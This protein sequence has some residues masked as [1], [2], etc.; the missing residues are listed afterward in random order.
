MKKIICLCLSFLMVFS[1]FTTFSVVNAAE[2]IY[3]DVNSD[4]VVDMRDLLFFRKYLAKMTGYNN[5]TINSVNAD[6][7]CNGKIN[8][9][10]DVKY[11]I[12]HLSKEK[13]ITNAKTYTMDAFEN[14]ITLCGRAVS[15]DGAIKLS[16]SASGFKFK[17]N[18]EGDIQILLTTA[19]NG[20]LVV[21]VDEDYDNAVTVDVSANTGKYYV[22]LGLEK[23]EHTIMIQKATEWSVNSLFTIN[24]L[25]FSGEFGA[26]PPEAKT[27][28][29][30]FYGDS[31]TSGYG[32]L[33]YNGQSRAGSWEYQDGCKTYA[34]FTANALNADYAVASA[35]GHGVIT[36]LG[37][38]T[39]TYDKFFDY[40]LIDT[41]TAWSR[42]D[43]DADLIV[44]NYGSNDNT[45]KGY[46]LD[47]AAFEAEC[48]KIIEGMREEN[49]DVQILWVIGMN[50]VEDS[51]PV[52]TSLKNIDEKYDYVNFYK[53]TAKHSGGDSHPTVAEHKFHAEGLV[54]KIKALYPDM[55]E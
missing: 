54:A 32:N 23:G 48:S 50:T 39:Q 43:Y 44:I 49:P 8:D 5:K 24:G 27:R 19:S 3:G 14:C 25:A 21:T 29:I 33:T 10:L 20:K 4:G 41:K 34:A 40:S 18:C 55:F 1:V 16:Q 51:A 47:T 46:D 52:I 53:A 28:R 2:V 36:G 9:L 42:A 38:A 30:E 6:I 13:L 37:S 26:E 45:K 17:A 12:M 11:L 15:E 35:S 31:I 22:E 7:N